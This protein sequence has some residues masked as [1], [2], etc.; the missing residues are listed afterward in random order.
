MPII[1]TRIVLL[2]GEADGGLVNA[3]YQSSLPGDVT[4]QRV[5]ILRRHS[6]VRCVQAFFDTDVGIQLENA[7]D[8]KRTLFRLDAAGGKNNA[9]WLEKLGTSRLVGKQVVPHRVSVRA[10]QTAVLRGF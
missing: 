6:V 9:L 2:L 4:P 3:E 7:F 10:E 8:K 5:G 1:R